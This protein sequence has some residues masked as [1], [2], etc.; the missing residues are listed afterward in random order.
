MS[1]GDCTEQ[2]VGENINSKS[3]RFTFDSNARMKTYTRYP[4]YTVVQG[5]SRTGGL[6]A[7]LNIV[8]LVALMAHQSIFE[9][10]L[11]EL[12]KQFFK[13][14]Q[15]A[16]SETLLKLDSM[17]SDKQ[18]ELKEE[19]EFDKPQFTTQESHVNKALQQTKVS[20]IDEKRNPLLSTFT[21][22]GKNEPQHTMVL[23][24]NQNQINTVYIDDSEAG[25][26]R[27]G[28]EN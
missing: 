17:N 6:L 11:R 22:S 15:E 3:I 10:R 28:S 23:G 1:A 5:L 19:K 4:S 24:N 25:R 27:L 13:E 20:D 2:P 14:Q 7:I 21:V 9:N 16:L 18:F 12:D 26:D 8:G